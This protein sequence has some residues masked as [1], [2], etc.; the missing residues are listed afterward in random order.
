[1]VRAGAE[2]AREPA[3]YAAADEW[4]ERAL[5]LAQ[6]QRFPVRPWPHAWGPPLRGGRPPL[7]RLPGDLPRPRSQWA[8]Q[9]VV[10]AQ[11]GHP[12][13]PQPEKLQADPELRTFVNEK[14]RQRWSPQ[15]ITGTSPG[16]ARTSRG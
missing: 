8:L 12:A 5:I 2:V 16:A 11:P 14:L 6:E 3:D 15:Q 4:N 10:V 7:H 13:P 1:M 9:P